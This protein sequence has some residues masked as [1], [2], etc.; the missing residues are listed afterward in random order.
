MSTLKTGRGFLVIA[1]AV[2]C[3]GC[4]GLRKKAPDIPEATLP[5]WVGRVV[6]VDAEHRF[7]LVDTGGP[8]RLEPGARVLTFRDQ[9]RTASLTVTPESKPPFLA[10][11]ITEGM[12]AT[13][14]QVALDESLPP[15]QAPTE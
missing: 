2:V 11:E 14:D 1:L 9:S 12:P 13:G 15:E 8:V 7:A 5:T 3:A 4:A 10:L 6:M